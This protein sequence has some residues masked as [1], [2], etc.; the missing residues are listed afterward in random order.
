MES[1][2]EP[3]SNTHLN[4]MSDRDCQPASVAFMKVSARFGMTQVFTGHNDPKGNADT[5]QLLRTLKMEL[6]WLRKRASPLELERALTPW[7][8]WYN[9]W[10]SHSLLGCRTQRQIEQEHRTGHSTQFV[11]A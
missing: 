1:L 2:S 3:R 4:E 9:T 10:R 7:I 5:E 6:R 11:A 8:D